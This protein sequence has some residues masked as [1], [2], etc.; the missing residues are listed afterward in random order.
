MEGFREIL[1]QRQVLQPCKAIE[2]HMPFLQVRSCDPTY[3]VR[4]NKTKLEIFNRFTILHYL[5]YLIGPRL[6]D[7]FKSRF[8][9]LPHVPTQINVFNGSVDRFSEIV[10]YVGIFA[11]A[12]RDVQQVIVTRVAESRKNYSEPP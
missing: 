9:L 12:T 3:R 1:D 7:M 5:S 11:H 8:K 10:A 6:E 2:P 4:E